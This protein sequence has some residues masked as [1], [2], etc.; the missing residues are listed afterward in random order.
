MT[1][2]VT[3]AVVRRADRYLVTRRLHGTHLEGC[4]EFPGGKCEQGESHA[5]ALRREMREELDAD[6]AVGERILTV[7]HDYPDRTVEL[8][9]YACGLIGDPRPLLGQEV[10][11]ARKD[12][13]R[14][15]PFPPADEALIEKL[16]PGD[17]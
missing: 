16:A 2:V 4:W 5:D 8:Q 3:A 6:V 17:D 12:E 14:S 9:F 7:S 15:L 10:R 11:W 1:L 13:L